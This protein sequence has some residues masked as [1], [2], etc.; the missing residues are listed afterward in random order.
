MGPRS[1]VASSDFPGVASRVVENERRR[2]CPLPA[3]RRRQHQPARRRWASR[4]TAATP[5]SASGSSSAARSSRS[6]PGSARVPGPASAGRSATCPTSSSPPG[7]PLAATSLHPPRRGRGHRRPRLRRPPARSTRPGRSSTGWQATLEERRAGDAH[8]VGGA[9]RREAYEDWARLLVEAA[10]RGEADLR[11][12]PP[13][14]PGRR[15]HHRGHERRALL[16][17]RAR[18]PRALTVSRDTFALGYTNGTIG[19][20]AARRGPPARR[21]GPPRERMPCRT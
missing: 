13:G 20:L 15:H 12:L 9:R 18:D 5:R 19:Y 2:A 21:L 11:S 7:S 3:G 16:R 17:D 10:G 1:A 6:P 14:D 4:S 8:G